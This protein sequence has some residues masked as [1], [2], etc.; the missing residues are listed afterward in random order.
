M[1]HQLPVVLRIATACFLTSAATAIA[2]I[3]LNKGFGRGDFGPYLFWTTVFSLLLAALPGRAR[4][5]M[6]GRFR[7]VMAITGGGLAGL[8]W[9]IVVA[10]LL[11]PWFGAFSFPVLFCWVAGGVAGLVLALPK[12]SLLKQLI[13]CA[14][15]ALVTVAAPA[16]LRA[17]VLDDQNLMV[18]YVR[19]RPGEGSLTFDAGPFGTDLNAEEKVALTGMLSGGSL[20]VA[21]SFG[22]GKGKAAR[23][24]VVMSHQPSAQFELPQPKA[25]SVIYVQLHDGWKKH[26]ESA[27]TLDRKVVCGPSAHNA[28]ATHCRIEHYGGSLSGGEAFYW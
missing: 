21:G 1:E 12:E 4:R 9:T 26:P 5:V 7:Y 14:C 15:F 24:V 20:E 28:R 18:V 19:W 23:M 10:Y 8:L 22:T 2:H 16:V 25:T 3:G 6:E 11:G 13:I 27:P 17:A